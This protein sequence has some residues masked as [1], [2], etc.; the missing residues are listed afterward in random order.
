MGLNLG[1]AKQIVLADEIV[2]VAK[3]EDNLKRTTENLIETARKI[4]LIINKNETKYMIVSR[5]EYPQNTI[6]IK[7]LNFE[8][9][10]KFKYLGVNINARADGHEEVHRRIIA[11]NRCYFALA[12]LLKSKKLSRRT[13]IR[14]FNILV[15]PLVLCVHGAWASTKADETKLMVFERKVL[16]RIFGL[17]R[18]EDGVYEIRANKDLNNLFDNPQH[19]GNTQK[20]ENKLGRPHM[21][22]KGSTYHHKVETEQNTA[23]GKTQTTVGGSIKGRF[24]KARSTE[25]GRDNSVT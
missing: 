20:P 11:G 18:N 24:K 5:K 9:V 14:L 16:R 8:R 21:E 13:K 19:S 2:L 4:G 1:Q 23:E 3:T 10:D 22:S 12:R 7:D 15:R 25:G 6:K 17:K